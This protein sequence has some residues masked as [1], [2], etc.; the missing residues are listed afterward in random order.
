MLGMKAPGQITP[1]VTGLQISTSSYGQAVPYVFGHCRVPHKLIYFSN[2]QTHQEDV[3]KGVTISWFSVNADFLLGY[4]PFE[5]LAAAWE[6]STWYYVNYGSQTFTGSGTGTSFQ[7]TISNNPTPVIMIMGV[8]LQVSYNNNYSDY[9]NPYYTKSFSLSGSS[10]LPLYNGL[11]PLPNFGTI[12]ASQQPYAFY[13]SGIADPVVTVLFPSPVTNPSV[14]V[15]YCRV[16]GSNELPGGTAGKKGGANVPYQKGG[17]V[18]E[19]TLGLGPSGNTINYPEFSGDAGSN[20]ALGTSAVLPQYNYEVKALFGMGNNSPISSF[21]PGIAPGDPH[22]YVGATSSGDCCPA[23]IIA[24]LITSGNFLP[25]Q[26]SLTGALNPWIWN[27][28]LGFSSYVKQPQTDNKAPYFYSRYGGILKDE[29]SLYTGSGGAVINHTYSRP[30]NGTPTNG[31]YSNPSNVWDNN[32]ITYAQAVVIESNAVGETWAGFPSG[33]TTSQSFLNVISQAQMHAT[34]AVS[35]RYSTDG[36]LTW[37]DVYTAQAPSGDY[38]SRGYTNDVILLPSGVSIPQIQVRAECHPGPDNG[39]AT[40]WIYE[41]Y[42]DTMSITGGGSGTGSLGLMK[43]RNYCMAYNIFISGSLDSQQPA[44]G[45]LE[46]LCEVANCAAVYDGTSL[47]FIPYCEVSS[48]GNGTSYQAPTAG[49]PLFSFTRDDLLPQEKLVPL[50]AKV[51]RAKNNFNSLQIGF[52]DA[53]AQFN[54][55]FVIISDSMDI[56]TQGPLPGS[57]RD[58]SYITCSETALNVG[59]AILRRELTS[60]ERVEYTFILP[61]FWSSILTPMD[62]VTV[63]DQTMSGTGYPIPVRIKTLTLDKKMKLTVTAEPFVYGAS[64]PIPPAAVGGAVVVN[65]PPNGS[66]DPGNVNDP[67]IF[68]AVPGIA[69]SPQIWILISGAGTYW[70]GAIVWLSTDGGTNYVQIGTVSSRS[71]QGF[72]STSTYP[73]HTDPD[74]TDTLHVDL[75]ESTGVLTSVTSAQQNLFL[76]SLCYLEGGGTVIV[77]GQVLTI[78]YELI[79]FQTATLTAANKYDLTQPIRRGVFGTP[80]AAHTAGSKFASLVNNILFKMNLPNTYIGTTLHFKFTS[81]NLTGGNLQTLGDATDYTFTPTGQVGWGNIYTISPQPSVYQG[82]SGGWPA[83]TGGDSNATSWTDP[84]KVYFPQI[85]ASFQSKSIIYL[86]RDAGLSVFT[87]SSGGQLAYTS[88]YDPA[89]V[90]EGG[91]NPALNAYA[92]LSPSTH[93]NQAGYI[94]IGILTSLPYS[95]GGGS[96]GGGTSNVND[97]HFYFPGPALYTGSQVLV[98]DNQIENVTLPTGLVG[99]KATC[100]VAPTGSIS[101]AIK[102][103]G[104]SVGSIDFAANTTTGTFTFSSDVLF[105]SGGDQLTLVAPSSPDA[106]FTGLAVSLHGTRS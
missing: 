66:T 25:D 10:Q 18:F 104:V 106:T 20:I 50:I 48:Y 100:D 1:R 33:T 103:N 46:T 91:G 44:A 42:V 29:P 74:N 98:V 37:S 31:G 67:V 80:T 105:T 69:T 93:Y 55:D 68:E 23:D 45:V 19:R 60:V 84:S 95:Q 8:S 76:P 6:N 43:I 30:S 13:N 75:T 14:T 12:L 64:V 82:K 101:V 96:G 61:G 90:G 39:S 36:G 22:Q 92:D 53:R 49:G 97:L 17:L 70:G 57:Q 99:S 26:F 47:D 4:G 9:V 59:W 62:L 2:F 54:D 15:Y 56:T 81:F 88:V 27:H 83:G 51:A 40:H 73:N 89:Q 65:Q 77:N 35:V 34:G 87:N 71:P 5:G 94:Q 41:I 21:S 7:F 32:Q 79:A 78:P 16:G 85:T 3:G 86:P 11:F 102:K 28:G 38:G 52:K 24:D 72:V 58:Y 63:F